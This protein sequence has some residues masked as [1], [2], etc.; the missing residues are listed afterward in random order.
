MSVTKKIWL[1]HITHLVEWDAAK[2][3]GSYQADSFATQGFIHCSSQQQVVPVAN[4]YYTGQQGLVLLQIDPERVG[5]P[6]RWEN[7]EGGSELFPHIYGPLATDAVIE[8]LNF[9]PRP[10]GSFKFPD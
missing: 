7:L 8:V 1:Y 3:K 5:V 4:R 9:P 6:V 10:D 2:E